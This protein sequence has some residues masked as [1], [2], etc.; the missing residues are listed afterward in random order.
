MLTFPAFL[1]SQDPTGVSSKKAAL[2]L[3]GGRPR[4]C[5]LEKYVPLPWP[6]PRSSPPSA[7]H[8]LERLKVKL[9]IPGQRELNLLGYRVRTG[10]L[11]E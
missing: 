8:A 10:F 3:C 2:L 7:A 1:P 6:F 9:A 5:Q 11:Y 4:L